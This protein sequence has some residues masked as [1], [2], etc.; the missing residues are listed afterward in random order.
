MS[1]VNRVE[2]TPQSRTEQGLGRSDFQLAKQRTQG[3]RA[4]DSASHFVD[5]EIVRNADN[6]IVIALASCQ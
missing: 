3:R 6:E 2:N 5:L 4:A 1:R